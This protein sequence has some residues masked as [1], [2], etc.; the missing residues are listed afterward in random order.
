VHIYVLGPKQLG[1]FFKSLS[2]LYEAV[3][4]KFSADFYTSHFLTAISR[5]SCRHLA[6]KIRTL[7]RFWKGDQWSLLKKKRWKQSKSAH[8]QWHNKLTWSNMSRRTKS[9]LA[10]RSDIFAPTASERSPIFHKPVHGDRGRRDHHFS[11]QRTFFYRATLC[12]SAVFAVTRC[13]Y[14]RHVVHY[15]QKAEDIVKLLSRHGSPIV[16]VFWPPVPNSTGNPVSMAQNTREVGKI[17]DFRPKS[18]FIS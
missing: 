7:Y 3:R 4:T 5:K 16:L 12:V 10:V 14:V 17:C 15:I 8:K 18:P 11:I 2:Y 13:L 1:G 6:T 9:A